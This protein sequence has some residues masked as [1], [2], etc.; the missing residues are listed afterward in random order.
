MDVGLVSFLTKIPIV[1]H[2]TAHLKLVVGLQ[3]EAH[4][5]IT[6]VQRTSHVGQ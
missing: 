1:K 6:S 2:I 5:S 3:Y 4:V